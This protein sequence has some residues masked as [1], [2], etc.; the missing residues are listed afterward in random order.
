MRRLLL[1]GGIIS[2]VLPA[3]ADTDLTS[4]HLVNDGDESATCSGPEGY[5]GFEAGSVTMSP[6]YVKTCEPGQY[7]NATDTTPVSNHPVWVEDSEHPGTF[8]CKNPVTGEIIS[9]ISSGTD[10]A[11]E[12]LD[13]YY[14][15]ACAN[16]GDGRYFNPGD[17]YVSP[18]GY[19]QSTP[20]L[21]IGTCPGEYPHSDPLSDNDRAA[22]EADCYKFCGTDNTHTTI[23]SADLSKLHATNAIYVTETAHNNGEEC[24]AKI[25][26]DGCADGY[27]LV[28]MSDSDSYE[29]DVCEIGHTDNEGKCASA[30]APDGELAAGTWFAK[31]TVNHLEVSGTIGYDTQTQE[32]SATVNYLKFYDNVRT[33]TFTINLGTFGAAATCLRNIETINRFAN[34]FVKH[35]TGGIAVAGTICLAKTVNITWQDVENPGNAA[36]CTYG[37]DLNFPDAPTKPNYTFKGWTVGKIGD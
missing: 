12:V 19:L 1:I 23:S 36:T 29:M 7:Y 6:F 3:V 16:V 24:V 9:G 4:Y 20:D 8:L 22:T 14:V 30:I 15:N 11:A 26:A 2:M 13:Y 21:D 27:E 33:D 31:S 5:T 25:A 37:E 34:G 35:Y 32:C 10:C 28:D 18:S 17:P